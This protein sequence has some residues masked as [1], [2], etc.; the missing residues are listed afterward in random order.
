MSLQT[1]EQRKRRRART[2]RFMHPITETVSGSGGAVIVQSVSAST[3]MFFVIGYDLSSNAAVN[4][5]SGV[6][7]FSGH[8]EDGDEYNPDLVERLRRLD[9]A[10]PEAEFTNIIDMMDWLERG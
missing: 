8:A 10:P 3:N 5:A 9:A 4:L 1:L 7:L 6:S 2:I